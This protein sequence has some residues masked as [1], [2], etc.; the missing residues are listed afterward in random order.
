[1][2]FNAPSTAPKMRLTK[3]KCHINHFCQGRSQ[4][5]KD[6]QVL[7]NLS[8]IKASTWAKVNEVP[9]ST[10]KFFT[11]TEANNARATSNPTTSPTTEASCL[12][13]S[14]CK[15]QSIAPMPIIADN[16]PIDGCHSIR[17]IK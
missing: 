11:Y 3:P 6:Q 16:N 4:Q 2:Y 17:N 15:I 7:S 9:N 12:D 13:K 10:A 14:L 8:D 5:E 1:M